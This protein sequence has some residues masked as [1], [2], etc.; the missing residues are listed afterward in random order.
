MNPVD[1]SGSQA[2]ALSQDTEHKEESTWYLEWGE[3]ALHTQQ[4]FWEE[5]LPAPPIPSRD[6]HLGSSG[7][8]PCDYW[9]DLQGSSDIYDAPQNIKLLAEL[10][11]LP[12]QIFSLKVT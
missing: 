9:P 8:C 7:C 3:P 10:N 5:C 12:P 11:F 4:G 1:G 2:Q 6:W